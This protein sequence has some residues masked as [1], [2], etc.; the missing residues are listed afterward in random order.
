MK[1][2]DLSH[3]RFIEVCSA[4][5]LEAEGLIGK[6]VVGI[7][8]KTKEEITGK[9]IGVDNIYKLHSVRSVYLV[10]H[11]IHNGVTEIEDR[12]YIDFM[13]D[14]KLMVAGKEYNRATVIA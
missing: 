2:S 12:Y 14:N 7:N 5:H 8:V 11:K 9:V 13:S 10:L 1:L 3:Q 6:I 4:G